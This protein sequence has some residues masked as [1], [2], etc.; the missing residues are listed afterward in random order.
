MDRAR[1]AAEPRGIEVV[2]IESWATEPA[3]I[4]FLATDLR[5]RLD[6]MPANTKVLFTA[7]S[8][9]LRIIDAGDPYPDQLR[10]TAVAVAER[11]GLGLDGGSAR[12]A[13]RGVRLGL[14]LPRE[15]PGW[16]NPAVYQ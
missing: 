9:P 2:P 7:H 6:A 10:S 3:F 8:L 12:S 4:E 14:G 13:G 15:G 16:T 1:A 5:R 11:A